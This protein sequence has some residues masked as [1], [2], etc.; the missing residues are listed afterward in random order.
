MTSSEGDD[1]QRLCSAMAPPF[2]SN[3][4]ALGP[5]PISSPSVFFRV[6]PAMISDRIEAASGYIWAAMVARWWCSGW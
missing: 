2:L 6:L 5:K 4:A 3:L 1:K